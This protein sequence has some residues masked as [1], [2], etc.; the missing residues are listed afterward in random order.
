MVD[1]KRLLNESDFRYK[2]R[3]IVAK[4]DKEIDDDWSDIV[5]FLQL[6][7]SSDHLRKT[8]YGIYES[9]Q[10][11]K[12]LKFEKVKDTEILKEMQR[13]HD[14]I[15]KERTKLQV[16]NLEYN[17]N[18]KKD[19]RFDL[20]YEKIR[21]AVTQLE[22]PANN[23]VKLEKNYEFEHVMGMGD[24][25]FGANFKSKNNEYSKDICTERLGL[26][27]AKT[28]EYVRENDV[29]EL[30]I[31]NVA[32]T[33]QGILRMSDLQ[34]NEMPVVDAVVQVARLLANFLNDLSE[35][36]SIKYYHCS[37]SNHSQ[38][39]PLN[40]KA[41]E[42]ATED[43]ERIIVNYISDLLARN[44][45]VEVISDLEKEF[46]ELDILG[47]KA[48]ILHGHQIKS[49]K[50]VVKDLSN[51][52]RTFY[53]YVFLGHRHSANEIIVAE[54]THHN[55]EVLTCPSFVG[56]DPYADKLMVGSKAMVKIYKF[57]A[58]HGHIGSCNIILN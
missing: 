4:I 5:D 32:D 46:L 30:T 42:I 25:H 1:T 55:V 23:N 8:A 22:P 47:F 33:I 50:N 45:K 56:S 51:L 48:I 13:K 52:H 26:L 43:M 19:V 37:A 36:V 18:T 2:E 7:C 9:Y 17:R 16:V 3:L 44:K 35:V 49:V 24:F 10:N 38:T 53:D 27:L 40:S 34:I 28:K 39:R 20:F 14:S 15:V 11:N 57:E 12:N 21:D 54:G 41:S 6:D 31:V 58:T 29:K